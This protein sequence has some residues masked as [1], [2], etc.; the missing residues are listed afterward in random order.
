ME[1]SI[2]SIAAPNPIN[3][4]QN[5]INTELFFNEKKFNLNINQINFNEIIFIISC[6]NNN[7]YIEYKRGFSIQDFRDLSNNF[8]SFTLNEIS[9]YLI[10]LIKENKIKIINYTDDIIALNLK[11]LSGNN[12]NITLNLKKEL[13]EKEKINQLYIM[14]KELKINMENKDKKIKELENKIY[15]NDIF[16]KEI[17]KELRE[18]EQQIKLIQKKLNEVILDFRNFREKFNQR[19]G[20]KMKNPS[21]NIL[22]NILRNSC[23]FQDMDEIKLL[24]SNISNNSTNLKLLYSSRIDKDNQEKLINSYIGKN[25]IIIL[26]KTDKLRRFG[27]YAHECFEKGQFKKNDNKAFLFNLNKKTIFKSKGNETSICRDSNTND[28]INFGNGEDLKIFHNFYTKQSI[29]HQGNNDYDYKKESFAISGDENFNVSSLEI[30]QA[31]F[32]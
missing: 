10:S 26:V 31:I 2:F 4:E 19:I 13:N 12:N 7:N 30:Y 5:P 20:N 14:F 22:D 29:T 23:I 8:R 9:N 28:Y 27:G 3:N 11:P 21:K 25:D 32:N 18:K 1:S 15:S 24:L 6:K 17:I 16:K